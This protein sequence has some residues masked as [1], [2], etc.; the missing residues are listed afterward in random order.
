MPT[1]IEY[2]G[3]ARQPVARPLPEIRVAAGIIGVKNCLQ[4]V[5]GLL[6]SREHFAES[7]QLSA[8]WNGGTKPQGRMVDELRGSAGQARLLRASP[9]ANPVGIRARHE[10]AEQPNGTESPIDR[11]RV[12]GRAD[13]G[14]RAGGGRRRP[15]SGSPR[16]PV[17]DRIVSEPARS[18]AV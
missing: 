10:K 1:R 9:S 11:A 13:R 3:V 2:V 7:I 4:T 14:G 5:S 6:G 8:G 15:G 18:K 16:D 17:E 12:D